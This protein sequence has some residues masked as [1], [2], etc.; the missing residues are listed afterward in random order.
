MSKLLIYNYHIHNLYAIFAKFLDISKLIAGNLVKEQGNLCRCGVVLR[1]SDL[2]VVALSMAS[3]SISIDSESLLFAKLQ[4]YK[5]EIPHLISRKQYNN[6]HKF[7]AFPCN[8]I[9]ERMTGS[10]DGGENYF[11]IDSKPI[12]V[13]RLSHAK[14]CSF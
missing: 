8:T 6:S 2:E 5:F 12:E 9:R 14:C 13:C 4:E 11:C 1:F 3:E 10:I 7:T